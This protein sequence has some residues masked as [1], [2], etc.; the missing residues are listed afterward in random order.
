MSISG[1][2][3]CDQGS[4]ATLLLW[5]STRFHDKKTLESQKSTR[6]QKQTYTLKVPRKCVA[7]P[8][9]DICATQS[10]VKGCWLPPKKN[11]D[12]DV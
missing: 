8:T 2:K 12:G 10:C 3:D 5:K 7:I 1:T 11:P 4:V 6:L 9:I